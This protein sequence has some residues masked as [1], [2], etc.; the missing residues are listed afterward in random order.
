MKKEKDSRGGGGVAKGLDNYLRSEKERLAEAKKRYNE[1]LA[2]VRAEREEQRKLGSHFARLVY[3][4]NFIKAQEDQE[5]KSELARE[6]LELLQPFVEKHGIKFPEREAKPKNEK[7][8]GGGD[9][10]KEKENG[11]KD[12]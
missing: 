1:A 8:G 6:A 5:K 4:K 9:K 3:V 7:K 10:K 2:K 11:K 12:K